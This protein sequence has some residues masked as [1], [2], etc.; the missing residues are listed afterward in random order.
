MI[1]LSTVCKRKL[2]LVRNDGISPIFRF[3][4]IPLVVYKL[5]KLE[6]LLASNNKIQTVDSEAMTSLPRIA[7]LDLQNNDISQV[8]PGLGNCTQLRYVSLSSKSILL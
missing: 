8:P 2:D 3:T 1:Y 7:T 4:E 5:K 6:N